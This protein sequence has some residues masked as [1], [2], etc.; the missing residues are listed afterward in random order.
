IA[1]STQNKL[2]TATSLGEVL[3]DAGA[4]MMVFSSGSSGQAFLQNHTVAGGIVHPEIILPESLREDVYRSAGEP[5]A[6]AEPNAAQHAWAA[7]AYIHYGLAESGPLVSA[8]WFSDPDGAAHS[9]GIGS[10]AAMKSIRIVDEQ[11]G[12]ILEAI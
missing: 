1:E 12:R 3:R 2:L 8:I 10:E 11:F 7:Q 6:S 4:R 9:E 5:P